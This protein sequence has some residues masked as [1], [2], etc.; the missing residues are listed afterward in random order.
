MAGT[1]TRTVTILE[2]GRSG[3]VR[4]QDPRGSLRGYWEFGGA[5]VVVIIAMG[6]PGGWPRALADDREAVL[7]FIAAEAIRQRSPTSQ[8]DIDPASG[9]ILLREPG[10]VRSPGTP[11]PPTP[12]QDAAAFVTRYRGVRS[13]FSQLA[14]VATLVLGALAWF[15]AEVLVV[16]PGK[17]SPI[18]PSVLTDTH[19]ATLISTLQP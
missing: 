17:G 11:P 19:V 10:G 18:E 13:R 3:E 4:Y 1:P 5:D 7:A 12:R 16:R 9:D 8:P 6:A 14:L 15:K 2:N